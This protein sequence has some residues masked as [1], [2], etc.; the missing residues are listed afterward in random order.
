MQRIDDEFEKVRDIMSSL[1]KGDIER[2]KALVKEEPLILRSCPPQVTD[3]E[4]IV[5]VAMGQLFQVG[6][7]ASPRL[8][9]DVGFFVKAFNA[10]SFLR[11]ISPASAKDLIF[12]LAVAKHC[13]Y[14]HPNIS[15]WR[16]CQHFGIG[17]AAA[18]IELNAAQEL[19]RM[20]Q[21]YASW[22]TGI[23]EDDTQTIRRSCEAFAPECYEYA[24]DWAYGSASAATAAAYR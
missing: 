6:Q 5:L 17:G 20:C 23:R 4:D 19:I 12:L 10:Y 22:L 24:I 2:T 1:N 13:H 7:Y 3:S 15:S 18:T 16:A 14:Y 8:K 11:P 9:A 21:Y